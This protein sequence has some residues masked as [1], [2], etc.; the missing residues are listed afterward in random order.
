MI[1]ILFFF[2]FFFFF[3]RTDLSLEMPPHRQNCY[4]GK[5][6]RKIHYEIK[7]KSI[8]RFSLYIRQRRNL[9]TYKQ[10]LTYFLQQE[11]SSKAN[12]EDL[13]T[14][15]VQVSTPLAP[16]LTSEVVLAYDGF[17]S[18]TGFSV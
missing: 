3:F 12:L 16:A 18:N 13:S 8:R 11:P 10:L 15:K 2:F 1:T 9:I 14:F 4:N 7:T 5:L 6:T 17:T